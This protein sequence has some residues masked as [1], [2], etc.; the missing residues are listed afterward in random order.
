MRPNV[1]A[2]KRAWQ[3]PSICSS[4]TLTLFTHFAHT[5]NCSEVIKTL[6]PGNCS[7]PI[8]LTQTN[9]Y[10]DD[11]SGENVKC[12]NV[13]LYLYA[14]VKDYQQR[15]KLLKISGHVPQPSQGSTLP[16]LVSIC[17]HMHVISILPMSRS[18]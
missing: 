3:W 18:I 15:W 5:A 13:V 11:M 4:L 2:G 17:T 9:C 8:H 6:F 10:T 1:L 16:L 14:V 12:S 7:L